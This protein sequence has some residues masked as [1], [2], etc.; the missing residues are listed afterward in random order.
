MVQV[1]MEKSDQQRGVNNASQEGVLSKV[2]S[3]QTPAVCTHQG[4]EVLYS[5]QVHK[6]GEVNDI[7]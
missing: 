5:D 4:G 3:G 6:E 7:K 2:W 1:G